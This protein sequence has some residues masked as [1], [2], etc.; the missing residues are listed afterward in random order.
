MTNKER[1][2]V[3]ASTCA[4][5]LQNQN[6]NNRMHKKIKPQTK[7]SESVVTRMLARLL[8]VRQMNTLE[9]VVVGYMEQTV[10]EEMRM[11]VRS[12]DSVYPWVTPVAS[13]VMASKTTPLTETV[14]SAPG[15]VLLVKDAERSGKDALWLVGSDLCPALEDTF[16]RMA[17]R[18]IF[19]TFPVGD[20]GD[21]AKVTAIQLSSCK[22]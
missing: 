6:T 11:L 2:P 1:R 4:G 19:H 3:R 20:A 13:D 5:L 7:A 9:E 17:V 22:P 12:I 14:I 10:N 16:R 8:G 18:G 15:S 21:Y